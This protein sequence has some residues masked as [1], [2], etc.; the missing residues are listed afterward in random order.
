MDH[1]I[2]GIAFQ[3]RWKTYFLSNGNG[4]DVADRLGKESFL[5]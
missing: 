1:V 4:L 2:K 3:F 5:F